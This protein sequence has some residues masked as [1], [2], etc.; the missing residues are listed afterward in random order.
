MK[1]AIN[2]QVKRM[3]ILAG[4]L[5]ESDFDAMQQEEETLKEEMTPN[6]IKRAVDALNIAFKDGKQ[7]T[8]QGNEVT[9][10]VQMIGAVKTAT[11]PIRLKDVSLE[12]ILVDGQ[13]LQLAD[14]PGDL[15]S[16]PLNPDYDAMYGP[17]GSTRSNLYK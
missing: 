15:P 8:V 10:L 2:E 9:G 16:Q 11:G 14:M 6:E 13:P 12:D 17:G 5:K 4:I 7:I 3:Q 1:R